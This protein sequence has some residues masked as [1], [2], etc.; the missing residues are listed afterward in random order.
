MQTQQAEEV[1][2]LRFRHRKVYLEQKGMTKAE[3]DADARNVKRDC[4]DFAKE[5]AAALNKAYG[6]GRQIIVGPPMFEN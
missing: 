1:P 6:H 5:L 3:V 2:G 4:I